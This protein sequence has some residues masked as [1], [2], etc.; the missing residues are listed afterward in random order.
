MK[1]I[2]TILTLVFLSNTTLAKDNS[3]KILFKVNGMVCSFCAQGITK[4]FNKMDEVKSTK[5]NLD[6][7]EVTLI[8]NR[9]KKLGKEKIKS[10]V[11]EAGFKYVEG[12]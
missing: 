4:K 11:E 3:S 2:I 1:K 5:V 9:G 6:K 12:K 10:T 8:L 7:M